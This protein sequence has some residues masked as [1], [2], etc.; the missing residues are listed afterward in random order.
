MIT[1][2]GIV[3]YCSLYGLTITGININ[4]SLDQLT[5]PVRKIAALFEV[6]VIITVMTFTITIMLTIMIV[7]I[8]VKCVQ[9]D[10]GKIASTCACDL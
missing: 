1:G 10:G 7:I 9:H 2:G 5:V 4:G 6:G 8:T 3:V